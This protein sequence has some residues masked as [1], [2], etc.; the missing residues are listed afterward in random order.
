MSPESAKKTNVLDFLPGILLVLAISIPATFIHKLYRPLSAVAIAIAAGIVLRNVFGLPGN[1]QSG[2]TFA[3]KRIL[4]LGIILLGVRLSFTEVLKLGGSALGIIVVCITAAILLVRFISHRLGLPDRLGTLIGVGTSI[5]GVSAIVA[6]SPAIEAGEEETAFAVGTITI[7]GL[8]AVIF[9]PIL[10]HLLHLSDIFFGTWAGT[11]VNDT[12]QVVAT[13]FIFSETAGKVATVVKLTRN[14][15][16]APVILILSTFYMMRKA[17]VP[18]FKTPEKK[19]I[20]YQK[21]FPLFVL[22]FV[23]MAILRTL[24]VFTPGGIGMIKTTAAF[25][26]ATAIAGVG[27]GTNFAAMKRGGLKPFYAGLFA[28]VLMA[29]ISFSL[30]K[31]FNIG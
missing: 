13:G 28:A 15:F 1:C 5:C 14:L 30:I 12:S 26:I 20:D 31:L 2:V 23:G 29:V 25:L 19:K 4:R 6:T 10:G 9:Y 27:L 11:A 7:F 22:G 21:T 16:M 8:L 17:K 24:G 18:G 3:V